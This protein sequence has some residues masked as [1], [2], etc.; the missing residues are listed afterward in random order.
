MMDVDLE[1]ASRRFKNEQ[2][3]RQRAAAERREAL[4]KERE[5]SRLQRAAREAEIAQR[6]AEAARAAEESARMREADLEKNRGIVYHARLQPRLCMDAEVKGV[7]RRAD[8]V[9]LP[10]SAA[11][12]LAHA[13]KNGQLFFELSAGNGRPVTHVSILDF[14]ADEGTIGM[15]P[16]VRVRFPP[17]STLWQFVFSRACYTRTH[18]LE[19]CSLDV[20]H[21][22]SV[23]PGFVFRFCAASAS[24]RTDQ[25]GIT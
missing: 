24:R 12:E 9:T 25:A 4:R 21:M 23:G 2:S 15:P 18:G 13:Y 6:E 17:R 16:E 14:T 8:K 7:R 19:A 11:A 1:F 3:S 20:V 5:V 10:R 22:K